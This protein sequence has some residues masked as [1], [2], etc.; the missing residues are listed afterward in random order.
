MLIYIGVVAFLKFL[1][2]Y[3]SP[4]THPFIS[5]KEKQYL[6]KELGSNNSTKNV[7]KNIPWR[8]ILTSAPVWSLIFIQVIDTDK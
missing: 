1:L 3:D 7:R 4:D 6:A 5:E 8:H 2:C